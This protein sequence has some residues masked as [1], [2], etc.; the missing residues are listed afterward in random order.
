ML[1]AIH[2]TAAPALAPHGTRVHAYAVQEHLWKKR[3]AALT[4]PT[5]ARGASAKN[6]LA[7]D[8]GGVRL[9]SPLHPE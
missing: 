4:R 5:L 3:G 8:I 9:A 2:R 7:P 1:I 6:A